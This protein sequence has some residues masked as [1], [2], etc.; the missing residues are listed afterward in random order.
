MTDPENAFK[1][2]PSFAQSIARWKSWKYGLYSPPLEKYTHLFAAL[3]PLISVASREDAMFRGGHSQASRTNRK[4]SAVARPCLAAP[5]LPLNALY[6]LKAR[7]I[8]KLAQY[9]IRLSGSSENATGLRICVPSSACG[10]SRH[11]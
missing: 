4:S 3:S 2:R 10:P 5:Q 7:R 6:A 8:S 1:Q 9:A 11:A